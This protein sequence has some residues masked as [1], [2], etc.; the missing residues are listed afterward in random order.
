MPWNASDIPSQSGKT[1]IVTGGN[2]GIGLI[3]ARELARHGAAVTIAC[4]DTGKVMPRS[5]TADSVPPAPGR[6]R[7]QLD[8]QPR[9]GQ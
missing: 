5:K 9:L 2:S 1:A 8:R 3:A 7:R 4:R 6:L